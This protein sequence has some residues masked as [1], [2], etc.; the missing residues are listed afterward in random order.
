MKNNTIILKLLLTL[1]LPILIHAQ[2]VLP[3]GQTVSLTQDMSTTLRTEI[4]LTSPGQLTIYVKNWESTYNWDT[5]YDR[6][7]I[8]NSADTAIAY[9]QFASESDPFLF[10]MIGDSAYLVTNI[11]QEGTYYIDFHS[12]NDWGWPEGK[13]TQNYTVKVTSL[14]VDDLYET[15]DKLAGAA[16]IALNQ[17]VTAYQWKRTPTSSV[18]NDEDYYKIVLPSPGIL[19]VKISD[20]LSVYN[21][22]IDYDRFYIYNDQTEAIGGYSAENPYFAAMFQDTPDG[23]NINLTSGGIY[24]LR[25]HSGNAYK[26]EPYSLTASFT[27]VNDPFEPNDLAANAAAVDFDIPYQAYQWRSLG[28]SDSV[29]TDEDFYTVTVPEA[30]KLTVT[31][32]DGWNS[33][34]NWG[35]DYDRLY[36]YDANGNQVGASGG[37]PNASMFS[38]SEISVD[39]PA[40]G[41]YIIRLHS[42]NTYS[43]NPY[44][45][46]FKF[47]A[48]SGIQTGDVVPEKY[49][50]FQ[51]YPNPF[52]PGTVIRYQLSAAS[53]VQLVIYNQLGQ[54]V[55]TLV[56]ERQE[57]GKYSLTFD[58][59][60]LSSGIYYYKITAGSF[61]QIRQM[62]LIK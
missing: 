56:N 5:D 36:F 28:A 46:T 3:L 26:T 34:Y 24:Y 2:T 39:L 57:T 38:G 12:G 59:S 27:S 29:W 44:S 55:K 31:V 23:I 48:L 40:S 9:N 18:K 51:N 62:I 58:A 53:D 16:T 13:T 14:P 60:D 8:Y 4:N 11:G 49:A 15:N 42:G 43:E 6:I 47:K 61:V 50:L 35:T 41:K 17:T 32:S 19:N 45:V 25:L 54:K 1:A 33:I 52:N 21:W 20:W 10:H 30:G 7:Y 37:S 22:G